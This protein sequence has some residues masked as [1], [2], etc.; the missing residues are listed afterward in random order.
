M[1]RTNIDS[2]PFSQINTGTQG[3]I[4]T[5][6]KQNIFGFCDSLVIM[7]LFGHDVIIINCTNLAHH[8]L[9]ASDLLHLSESL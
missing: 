7:F 5:Q 3:G 9:N 1:K 2:F 4:D 8:K 6:N